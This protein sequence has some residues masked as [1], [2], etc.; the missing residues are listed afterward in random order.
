MEEKENFFDELDSKAKH[1]FCTCQ[2]MIILFVLLAIGLAVAGVV[3]IRQAT[4]AITPLRKVTPTRTD[5]TLLQR[6]FDDL[7]QAPGAST[8]LVISEQE[9]TALF[10]QAIE[11]NDSFPIRGIQAVIN[12]EVIVLSGTATQYVKSDLQVHLLPKVID[13]RAS[14]A[15]IKVEA[16]TFGVPTTLTKLIG[17]QLDTLL[18][19]QL[20]ALK[21]VEVRSI[22]L[23]EGK[24][25]ISG[26]IATSPE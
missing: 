20:S 1:S 21:N 4:T 12:P 14:L 3:I 5:A 16:G 19:N 22:V 9:L 2:S 18:A 17:S 7:K 26:T 23:G 8:N 25:T 11:K 24:L 15:I 13:G 10:S 6:K